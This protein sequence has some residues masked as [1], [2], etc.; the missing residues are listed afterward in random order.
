MRTF[1][2]ALALCALALVGTSDATNA[3]ISTDG[4]TVLITAPLVS[5]VGSFKVTPAAVVNVT[6]VAELQGAWAALQGQPLSGD[7]TIQLLN[8]LDV[9]GLPAGTLMLTNQPYG[10]YITI[11]GNL[12]NRNAITITGPLCFLN[13][14]HITLRAVTLLCGPDAAS[15]T[16]PAL[17]VGP[18]SNVYV[19][20]LAVNGSCGNT[21]SFPAIYVTDVDVQSFS[22]LATL[23]PPAGPAILHMV[24]SSVTTTPAC[25]GTNGYGQGIQVSGI[26]A[27]LY[28]TNVQVST[29]AVYAVQVSINA[30]AFL[31]S[32]TIAGGNAGYCLW[33]LQGGRAVVWHLFGCTPNPN[34]APSVVTL[35]T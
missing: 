2:A 23:N 8:S 33:V 9:T 1:V 25:G 15:S 10:A 30:Q 5:I 6:T 4:S 24:D 29:T 13:V 31:S 11:Q 21:N 27:T 32:V 19:S 20:N 34:T 18:G 22:I 7:V 28:M 3:V 17:T 35:T 14:Q 16:S 26:G 12:Q